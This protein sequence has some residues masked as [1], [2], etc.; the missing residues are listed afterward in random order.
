MGCVRL[1][2]GLRNQGLSVRAFPSGEPPPW[3]WLIMCTSTGPLLLLPLVLH[4]LA[5]LPN[6]PLHSSCHLSSRLL[7]LPHIIYPCPPSAAFSAPL[8]L[9]SAHSPFASGALLSAAFRLKNGS[10]T[11]ASSQIAPSLPPPHLHSTHTHTHAHTLTHIHNN[12]KL[13]CQ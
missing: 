10:G 2:R 9:T 13:V 3:A 5:L 7:Y 4:A 11:T 8:L 12:P 1:R 6:P